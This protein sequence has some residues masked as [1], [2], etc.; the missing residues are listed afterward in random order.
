MLEETGGRPKEVS[1]VGCDC[2]CALRSLAQERRLKA[3]ARVAIE[4]HERVR[5]FGVRV[6]RESRRRLRCVFA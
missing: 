2:G 6:E 1:D 5:E 3:P 4:F